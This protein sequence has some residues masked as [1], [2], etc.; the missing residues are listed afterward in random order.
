MGGA[1]GGVG[2]TKNRINKHTLNLQQKVFQILFRLLIY[3]EYPN[4]Y[5]QLDEDANR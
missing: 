2:I 4:N 3:F 1:G 5:E